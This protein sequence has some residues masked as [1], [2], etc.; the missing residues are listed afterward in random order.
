MIAKILI[1]F[2]ILLSV[3]TFGRSPAV[4]PITGISIDE[5]KEVSPKQDPGFN[6]RQSDFVQETSLIAT[7]QPAERL[8]IKQT[9]SQKKSWPTYL[10]LF[11]LISLPF[12]L[13]YSIMKGLDNKSLQT[14]EG[15]DP[16]HSATAN[17]VDLNQERE[18][19]K[20]DEEDQSL[21]KAS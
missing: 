16:I 9:R 7:R 21:P 17:T 3:A 11:S 15:I 6:W 4:E 18:K 8:L 13:W 12:V 2:L 5:Y 14:Y 20:K 1:P 10:F 19:R